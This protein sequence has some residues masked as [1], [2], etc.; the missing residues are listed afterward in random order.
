MERYFIT[1][2]HGYIG[3]I[4]TLGLL[5]EGFKV[6]GLDC[7][8][9][10]RTPPFGR[11][12]AFEAQRKVGLQLKKD[13]RDVTEA[14]LTGHDAVIHLAA[15]PNDWACD[16][17]P[18]LT[19]D[20]N[21]L[22]TLQ[23]AINAKRAGVRK[24]IFA[25]SCSV[26]GVSGDK[27]INE[28]SRLA[29]I[30]P[31]GVSKLK[32]EAALKDMNSPEF[33]VVSMRN[34]TCYGVSPRMRFDMVLNN[35]VGWAYT[36]GIVN[37]HLSDG[38]A[39]RP[40]I[41]IDDLAT[42]YSL[43]LRA[44]AELVGGNAFSVVGENMIVKDIAEIVRENVPNSEVKYAPGAPKDWRSYN[45]SPSKIER[46]L[47]FSPIWNVKKGAQELYQ[48]YREFG[49]TKDYFED[50]AKY[51]AFWA[52]EQFTQLKDSGNVDERLRMKD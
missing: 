13:I 49:L 5:E 8:Y 23:L 3:N 11:L 15:L 24:F 12:D 48:A 45:V 50:R 20:I 36:T 21:Y 35:L 10:P 17:F 14:D 6:T 4:L 41:H 51:P 46:V 22:A 26:Y 29:P 40:L 32:A 34:A 44:P 31:Y 39:W 19:E 27:L 18:D 25:S 30:S 7:D 37:M 16:S 47:G 33:S 52:G 28:E 2:N 38:T 42:A 9:F 43:V 1:G